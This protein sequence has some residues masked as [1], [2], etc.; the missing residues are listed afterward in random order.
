MSVCGAVGLMIGVQQMVW[1]RPA[2]P[3]FRSEA[4]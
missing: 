4:L 2:G 1:P 3:P